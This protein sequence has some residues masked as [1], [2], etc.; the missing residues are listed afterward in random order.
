MIYGTGGIGKTSLAA[1]A[2]SP[3]FIDIDNG[4][5]KVHVKGV[6]GIET[7]QDMRAALHDMSIWTPYATI[8]IDSGTAAQRLAEAY[9]IETVKHEKGH[10]VSSVEGYG[11]GKG[12]QF[13]LETY[14]LL[15]ADLDA[16]RRKGRNV[17]LVCHGTTAYAPNPSGEDF[18]RNEPDLYQPPKTGRIR[19]AVKNWCDHMVFIDYDVVVTDGKAEGCGSRTIYCQE[20]PHYWAKSRSLEDPIVYTK[21]DDTFWKQLLGGKANG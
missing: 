9:T 3:A 14:R 13:V 19:D 5:G 17:V 18:L 20:M 7:F 8:V 16:Q 4:A 11:F 12:Y 1:L 21:G 2:P 15:L 10:W 6:A